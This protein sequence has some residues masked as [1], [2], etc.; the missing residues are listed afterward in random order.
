MAESGKVLEAFSTVNFKLQVSKNATLE[1]S[2]FGKFQL[3]KIRS[4]HGIVQSVWKSYE[5]AA[6]LEEGG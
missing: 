1:N 6:R 5:Y 3:W 4:N 2:Y